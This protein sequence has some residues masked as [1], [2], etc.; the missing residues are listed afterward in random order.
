MKVTLFLYICIMST[1]GKKA[2]LNWDYRSIEKKR[3]NNSDKNLQLEILKKWYPIGEYCYIH[4]SPMKFRYTII[5]YEEHLTFHSIII[6]YPQAGQLLKDKAT[7]PL[8]LY[9]P[10]EIL[11]KRDKIIDNLLR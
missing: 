5:G 10:M 8:N 4:D 9:L 7:H 2:L 1:F 11:I 6:G 3:F